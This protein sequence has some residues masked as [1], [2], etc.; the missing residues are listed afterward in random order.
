MVLVGGGI[1]LVLVA[2]LVLLPTD[3][4]P[5]W[6]SV[7]IGVAIACAIVVVLVALFT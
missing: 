7:Y 2:L 6:L 4:L 5:S 1:V 3:R